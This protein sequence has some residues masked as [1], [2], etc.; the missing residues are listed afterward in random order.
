[1]AGE[2]VYDSRNDPLEE[3][4]SGAPVPVIAVYTDEDTSGDQG[5]ELALII[6][7]T[8]NVRDRVDGEDAMLV[9]Q[10]DDGLELT[11]DIIEQEIRDALEPTASAAADIWNVIVTD[12]R[13][14]AS[15]RGVL[16]PEKKLRFAARQLLLRVKMLKD[17]KAGA[18]VPAIIER[19][20]KLLEADRHYAPIVPM[21]RHFSAR[22]AGRGAPAGDSPI[23]A[24]HM[25][26][27]RLDRL[28]ARN[29]R[30]TGG[31]AKLEDLTVHDR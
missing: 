18:P 22:Q 6:E 2:H 29:I 10:T 4:A 17:P 28:S 13:E 31:T 26:R 20:L 7:F 23:K 9:P 11:L 25:A 1:M 21:L 3:I 15:R 12:I 14:D 24:R 16:D 27:L 19:L 8:V 5:R 30:L